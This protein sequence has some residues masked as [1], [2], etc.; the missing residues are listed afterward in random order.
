ML[1]V[2]HGFRP[3]ARF[4]KTSLAVMLPIIVQQLINSLF[5]MVD[6]VMVGRLNEISLTAVA[7][8]N[9]PSNIYFGFFFGMAG[10]ASV[11]ISQYFGAEDKQTCQRVFSIELFLGLTVSVLFFLLLFFAPTWLMSIFVTDDTTI[12]LGVE[13]LKIVSFS[14]I[15][16]AVASVCI[17]SL[18]AIGKNRMPMLISLVSMGVNALCN[19]V[20][21]FGAFG[22]PALGVAG[23]A[24]GTVI[25][26]CAEL[27]CY[28]IILGRGK[29][30]FTL[31][32]GDA[33]RVESFVVKSLIR[34]VV[35]LT[36]NELLY[37]FG[38][39][40]LFWSY[41]RVQESAL[42]ALTVAEQASQI[43]NVCLT[44]IASAISVM[45]GAMLGANDFE[46]AKHNAKKLFS[47][48]AGISLVGMAIGCVGAFLL[49]NLFHMAEE[50]RTL[51]TWYTLIFSIFFPLNGAYAFMFF[52]LRAG[53]DTNAA[54]ILDG[55]YLWVVPILM[56]VLIVLFAG[57]AVNLF[58][59]LIL[60]QAAQALRVIPGIY[61]IKKQRWLKNITVEG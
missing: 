23:A 44:G 54:L 53:G 37:S 25:A 34:R 24:W 28:L 10:G 12:R 33:F 61:Y 52:L 32:F 55:V 7:T 1:K 27:I 45:V 49:P 51:A 40:M 5:N 57:G 42:A 58:V 56:S 6:T 9:K 2:L 36:V 22:A 16:A 30:Y 60:V 43:G 50:M 8:A 38:V 19:Y 17:F 14:Y 41:A 29:T 21:I 39:T 13:Y 3:D 20:L 4:V 31:H 18:R 35:P 46:G 26:R 48:S 15:P 47:I 11:L 59:L